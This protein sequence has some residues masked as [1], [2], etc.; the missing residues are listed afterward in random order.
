MKNSNFPINPMKPLS[1]LI[2]LPLLLLAA[3]C[4]D[5]LLLYPTRNEIEIPQNVQR[6][7]IPWAEGNLEV[8]VCRSDACATQS[9]QAYLL[10]F[11][12][13]GDRAEKVAH[14]LALWK[15]KPVEAWTVNRPG[16]GG[17]DGAA[18]ADLMP[19]A[20]L[21]AFDAMSKEARG[22]PILLWGYSVG[23]SEALCVAAQRPAAGLV[24]RNTPPL[25]ELLMEAHGWWNLWLVSG[26]AA[27]SIPDALDSLAQAP[28]CKT[29][30]LFIISE[31]DLIVPKNLQLRLYE[32]YAGPKKMVESTAGGHSG[33][34]DEEIWDQVEK[35][36]DWL[37]NAA[38]TRQAR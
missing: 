26:P 4:R 22:K 8:F 20:A 10:R 12:G 5:Q 29:P 11:I 28:N 32:A 23:G 27:A 18:S 7:L 30:A 31:G 25:R 17:S 9:P 16:F 15:T 24:L 13:A 3:G 6:K 1:V 2:L 21:A 33:V 14:Q 37:W 35:D 38:V 36:L 19:S 34:I